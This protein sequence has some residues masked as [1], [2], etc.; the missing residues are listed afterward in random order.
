MAQTKKPATTKKRTTR[1]AKATTPALRTFRRSDE[2]TFI[3]FSFTRQTL[4]WLIIAVMVV[5]LAAWVLYLQLQI[6]DIYNSIEINDDFDIQA[7]R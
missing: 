3:T 5:G 2:S 7:L 1:A 6:I 4:Y